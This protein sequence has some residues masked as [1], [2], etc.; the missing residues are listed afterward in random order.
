M[1]SQNEPEIFRPSIAELHSLADRCRGLE[2]KGVDDADGYERVKT[3]RKELGDMRIDITKYGKKKRGEAL[4]FQREVLRQEKEHLEIIVPLEDELREK[5]LAVD[6]AKARAARVILLPSRRALLN[7]IAS[8]LSDEE[9]LDLDEKTFASVYTEMRTKFFERKELE[10]KAKEDEKQRKAELKLAEERAAKKA[11][12][13]AERKAQLEIEK[14]QKEAQDAIDKVN[15]E[16]ADR[17]RIADERLATEQQEQVRAEKN[18]RY[19]KWLKENGCL[20]SPKMMPAELLNE[21]LEEFVVRR[22]LAGNF[23]LYRKVGSISIK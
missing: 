5:L 12:E 19:K 21:N 15:R 18:R 23:A 17:K 20:S 10:R 3:A 13:D 8:T 1:N 16:E 4:A 22:D 6:A 2:I 9:V 14:A 11:T 7:E